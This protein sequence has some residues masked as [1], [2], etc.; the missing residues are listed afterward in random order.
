MDTGSYPWK[1]KT[2]RIKTA[3]S[4][5]PGMGAYEFT[6][7]PFGLCGAP[8]SFQRLMDTIMRGLPFVATYMDDVLIHSSSEEIHSSHLE[9][10]LRRLQKAGL[11]L[12]GNK[13]QIGLAEVAFLGQWSR[14]EA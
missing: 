10:V 12:R 1:Y 7:M 6:R 11:T 3:F 5:G 9:Q 13:C 8:S 14:S 2:E 4:P